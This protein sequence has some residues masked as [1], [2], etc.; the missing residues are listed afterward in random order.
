[1]LR[2]MRNAFEGLSR[3]VKNMAEGRGSG[4][5][6]LFPLYK[7]LRELQGAERVFEGELFFPDLRTRVHGKPSA[8]APTG[9]ALTAKSRPHA[10]FSSAA[11]LLSCAAMVA[12]KDCAACAMR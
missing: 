5:L 6:A 3:W 12:K 8:D 2:A 10:G 9:E 4:E 1:M 7:R 11:C